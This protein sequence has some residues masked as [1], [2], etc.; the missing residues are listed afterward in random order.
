MSHYDLTEQCATELLA[1]LAE[2]EAK[3]AAQSAQA[4]S[5]ECSGYRKHFRPVI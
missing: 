5:M 1:L 2:I 4:V 3:G